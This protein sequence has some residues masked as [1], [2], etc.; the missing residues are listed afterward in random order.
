M[1]RFLSTCLSLLLVFAAHGQ[2]PTKT[3]LS[4]AG[5]QSRLTDSTVQL[6]DVRTAAEF[7]RGAL[8][9]AMQANWNDSAE[10]NRRIA[11]LQKDRPVYVYCQVGGRSAAAATLLAKNGFQV[12]ELEGGLT[13]WT[14]A[15]LPL[16]AAATV[17]QL[18]RKDFDKLVS[19]NE[20]TLVSI[21]GPW[22]PPCRTMQP[23]LD[24]LQNDKSLSFHLVNVD[25]GIHTSLLENLG[26]EA[27]PTYI[28]YKGGKE[29]WR[30]AGVQPIETLR[31]A[32][33]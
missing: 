20:I 16:L 1:I 5:F 32:L 14:R 10:F 7:R 21:G 22:C 6:L 19:A 24:S 9:H 3:L 27:L 4:P 17:E 15:G 26:V 18:K 25:A 31:T 11:H 2:Q 23:V 30:S 13:N 8:P 33:R 12:F 28:V 29:T